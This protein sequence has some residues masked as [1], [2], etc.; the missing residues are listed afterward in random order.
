MV[1]ETWLPLGGRGSC[2]DAT[3][4]TLQNI[5]STTEG[6]Y[7]VRLRKQLSK[8]Q[9]KTAAHFTTL[10]PVWDL[11]LTLREGTVNSNFELLHLVLTVVVIVQ[12]KLP[13]VAKQSGLF[14]D[15]LGH[16]KQPLS[17]AASYST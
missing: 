8:L 4:S 6:P 14:A 9:G 17:D 1:Q 15:T 13:G 11:V 2:D 7:R 16:P 10:V 12:G 5:H 3:S